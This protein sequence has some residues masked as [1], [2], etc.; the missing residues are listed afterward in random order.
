MITFF[1]SQNDAVTI[2]TTLAIIP[3]LLQQ[4]AS[5][6][7]LHPSPT[8]QI[9]SALVTAKFTTCCSGSG[10]TEHNCL[11]RLVPFA[12][13]VEIGLRRSPAG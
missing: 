6:F 11:D 2:F 8:I 1:H 9:G 3:R 12:V 5:R 7:S 10:R 13:D 4:T